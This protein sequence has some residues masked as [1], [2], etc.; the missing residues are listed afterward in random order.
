MAID[1]IFISPQLAD[2]I[3]GGFLNFGNVTISNHLVVWIDIP[4]QLLLGFDKTQDIT[5]SARF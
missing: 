1:S 2:R 5:K 3:Q 4:A